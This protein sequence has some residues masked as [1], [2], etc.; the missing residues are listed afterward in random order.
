MHEMWLLLIVYS[1]L[2][3]YI[4]DYEMKIACHRTLGL[5]PWDLLGTDLVSGSGMCHHGDF[6]KIFTSQRLYTGRLS[7]TTSSG[8]PVEYLIHRRFNVGFSGFREHVT[9]F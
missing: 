4:S 5:P 7:H 8:Q 2:L 3:C 9:C 1:G 6:I